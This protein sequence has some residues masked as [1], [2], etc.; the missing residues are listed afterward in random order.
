METDE[1]VS[2]PLVFSTITNAFS[3]DN[4]VRNEADI[5]LRRWEQ[6]AVPGFLASLLTIAE[7]THDEVRGGHAVTAHRHR[8]QADDAPCS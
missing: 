1:A 5:Q 8:H 7:Q 6:D 2:V 4:V 3:F